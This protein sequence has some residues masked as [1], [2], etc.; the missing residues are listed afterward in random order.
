MDVVIV[1][2][3][4]E[5]LFREWHQALRE[6][7]LAGRPPSPFVS[8]AEYYVLHTSAESLARHGRVALAAIQ[9]GTVVGAMEVVL[10]DRHDS[11]SATIDLGV[12]PEHRRQGIGTALWNRALTHIDAGQRTTIE[13][14]VDVP[15]GIALAHCPG[16]AFALARGFTSRNAEDH[17]ILALPLE[18]GLLSAGPALTG[19][20]LQSWGG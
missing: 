18:P 16:G 17:F 11:T 1:D 14:Q 12:P 10:T 2:P 3:G 19:Y 9:A 4:D 20:R 15:S 7:Q 6:G 8:A 5:L 13:T